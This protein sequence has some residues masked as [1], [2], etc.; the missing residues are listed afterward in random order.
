MISPD[1]LL[2]TVTFIY[3]GV[4][5]LVSWVCVCAVLIGT[6]SLRTFSGQFRHLSSQFFPLSDQI[7]TSSY[8]CMYVRRECF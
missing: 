6:V 5:G 3:T 2:L 8:V 1:M 7:N 4:Y